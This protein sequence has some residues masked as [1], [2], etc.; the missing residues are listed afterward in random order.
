MPLAD[1]T[2]T[3]IAMPAATRSSLKQ[4][5]QLEICDL[6]FGSFKQHTKTA[7]VGHMAYWPILVSRAEKQTSDSANRSA[8]SLKAN[9]S[10][11]CNKKSA[12]MREQMTACGHA[13]CRN[14][15]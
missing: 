1:Q 3:A 10:A 8:F 11:M 9:V 5:R 2:A 14:I 15:H 13:M 4:P 6:P 7:A 12:R